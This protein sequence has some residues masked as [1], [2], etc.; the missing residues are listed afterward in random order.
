MS[1]KDTNKKDDFIMDKSADLSAED[2]QDVS[3][4]VRIH[5]TPVTLDYS[6][7][8]ERRE[9]PTLSAEDELIRSS[10]R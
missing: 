8:S 3:G 6:E 2:L 5:W 4:G 7:S 9:T 10:L 1:K